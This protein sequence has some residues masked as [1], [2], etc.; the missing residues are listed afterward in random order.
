MT[1]WDVICQA[2]VCIL[3]GTMGV[4]SLLNIRAQNKEKRKWEAEN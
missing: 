4:L 2:L 3:L 1:Q